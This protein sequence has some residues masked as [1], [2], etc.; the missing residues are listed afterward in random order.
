M[1]FLAGDRDRTVQFLEKAFS[2]GS[3][4]ILFVIRYPAF[5]PFRSDPRFVDL[6]RRLNLPE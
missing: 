3:D 4:E 5:D 6:M 2:S 1:D